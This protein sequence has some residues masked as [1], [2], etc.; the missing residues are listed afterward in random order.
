MNKAKP[1]KQKKILIKQCQGN[2]KTKQSEQ[3]KEG[4]VKCDKICDK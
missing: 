1:V 2:M 3:I 4:P